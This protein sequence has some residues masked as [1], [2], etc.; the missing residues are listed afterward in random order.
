MHA[1]SHS[2]SLWNCTDSCNLNQSYLA[3]WTPVRSIRNICRSFRRTHDRAATEKPTPP[4]HTRHIIR[5]AHHK[6]H[7]WCCFPVS[8]TLACC[9]L[10][11]N[12]AWTNGGKKNKKKKKTQAAPKEWTLVTLPELTVHVITGKNRRMFQLPLFISHTDDPRIKGLSCL[13]SSMFV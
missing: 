10:E 9:R 13:D 7:V 2:L 1:H 11:I 8:V 3:K 5:G 6:R 12:T 4:R